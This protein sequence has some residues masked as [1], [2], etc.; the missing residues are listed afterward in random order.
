MSSMD[1]AA[2]TRDSS[3]A[4]R[5]GRIVALAV[6][7]FFALIAL[8]AGAVYLLR[9]N[10]LIK[11]FVVP[12]GAML[13]T[14][15]PNEI[16]VADLRAYRKNVPEFGDIVVFHPP[17]A[18]LQ[19][20][21]V[22]SDIVFVSRC[23]GVPGDLIEVR[24]G[25]LVRNGRSVREPYVRH[26]SGEETML[27]DFKIVKVGRDFWPLLWGAGELPN[28]SFK[29]ARAYQVTDESQARAYAALPPERIPRGY[30]LTMGDNR[31]ESFDGRMWGLVPG[32]NVLGKVKMNL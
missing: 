30:I 4:P 22:G 21:D 26:A 13:P 24:N 7:L 18:A 31:E 25:V 5:R 10:S 9:N 23:V 32:S 6:F 8:A 2:G 27:W 14:L 1:R 19:N 28:T 3:D 29:T 11:T 17:R 16:I 15:K 12:S 20:A